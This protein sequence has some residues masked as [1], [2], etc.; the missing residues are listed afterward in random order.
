MELQRPASRRA[1][2][3]LLTRDDRLADAVGHLA[4]QAGVGL[5]HIEDVA[6]AGELEGAALLCG[7]DVRSDLEVS[8][9]AVWAGCPV[10]GVGLGT[11]DGQGG[12]LTAHFAL[13]GAEEA[14]IA[15]FEQAV[16]RGRKGLR[17]G[18]IGAHGGVG[19][20]SLAIAL[21]RLASKQGSATAMVDLDPAGAG[22]AVHLGIEIGPDGWNDLLE[23]VRQGPP[24]EPEDSSADQDS[25]LAQPG[26]DS[27]QDGPLYALAS[28]RR[29]DPNVPVHMLRQGIETIEATGEL[30]LSVID[31][32]A[33]GPVHPRRLATWCD[34]L[35]LVARTDP[36]GTESLDSL[37]QVLAPAECPITVVWRVG[38]G[39]AA[40]RKVETPRGV[41]DV[42]VL[43]EEADLDQARRHGVLP[44][45]RRRGALASCAGELA[46][47]LGLTP[48]RPIKP[49][50]EPLLP[51]GAERERPLDAIWPVA[52][53]FE[54]DT[55]EFTSAA[56]PRL[57]DDDDDGD[58]AGLGVFV[59]ASVPAGQRA[60][61]R[62]A[63]RR[64]PP[65][66]RVGLWDVQW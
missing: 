60:S 2:A 26:P 29:L 33:A 24:P 34:R 59:A 53:G 16:D 58:L 17:V 28:A 1:R 57:V 55:E 9:A 62:A 18:I 36:L 56:P 20:S 31:A 45:E 43:G 54:P 22:L 35:V 25:P 38:R 40:K 14:L 37:L 32:S 66:E 27:Q 7:L 3:V 23:T 21:G 64:R 44:G 49:E 52:P 30:A 50:S 4:D 47:S 12:P 6:S 51:M 13:P 65:N 15:F 63:R 41:R 8:P 46:D 48:P 11:W 42:I 10:A 19:A 39:G 5:E 61:G